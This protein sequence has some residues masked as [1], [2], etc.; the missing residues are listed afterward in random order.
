MAQ[1]YD[2]ESILLALDDALM[3]QYDGRLH[4]QVDRQ[5]A[6]TNRLIPFARE[7]EYEV[8]SDGVTFH[9]EHRKGDYITARNTPI[10]DFPDSSAFRV[11]TF[12]ARFKADDASNHDFLTLDGSQQVL[13]LDIAK[14]GQKGSVVDLVGRLGSEMTADYN[15]RLAMQRNLTRTGRIGLVNGTPAENDTIHFSEATATPDTTDGL[16]VPID[17]GSISYF[18][19]G[20]FYDFWDPTNNEYSAQNVRCVHVNGEDLSVGFEWVNP[21]TGLESSG[22]I[23]NI[24]DNDEIYFHGSKGAGMHSLGSWLAEPAAGDSFIGGRNR[25]SPAY[26]W[27][28]PRSTRATAGSAAVRGSFL[29]DLGRVMGW[30]HD[31]KVMGVFRMAPN[32]LDTLRAD[33]DEK[34]VINQPDT[35]RSVKR[36]FAFGA[37]DVVYQHPTFGIVTLASDNLCPLDQIQFTVPE[38]WMS[39]YYEWKGVRVM[40]G[41]DVGSWK[42][43]T[44]ASPQ[45]GYGKAWRREYYSNHCD[46]CLRPSRQG[47]IYNVAAA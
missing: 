42:R 43:V 34:N 14:A 13:D 19:P 33:I 20:R 8:E 3:E 41:G 5:G 25:L 24:A 31:G 35:L 22:L 4:E 17:G 46:V 28:L 45:S 18:T 29:N 27:L 47:V 30:T 38:D 9:V 10:Q 12:K 2:S 21:G 26:Q 37:Q 36:S 7:G 39:L 16:R 23:T 15:E 1:V 32:I 6:T 11:E 40:P 44:A